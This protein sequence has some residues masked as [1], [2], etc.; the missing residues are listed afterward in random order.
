MATKNYVNNK[1]LLAHI[2]GRR[3]INEQ[4]IKDGLEKLPIDNYLGIVIM[5]IAKR[6]SFRPNFIN[7]SYK[8]EMVSD[9][10]ENGLKVIDNFDPAKSSNPFAYLTQ[11]MWNAFIRRI[12]I[13]QKQQKIKGALI[14]E[15]PL[16]ELFSTQEHDEE[17]VQYSHHIMDF[18]RENNF[19]HDHDDQKES[20]VKIVHKK[21][22]E[23]FF[24]E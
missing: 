20:K 17:G 14:S 15:M 1:E 12:Q 19:S 2:I 11:I 16:D 13:E 23:K 8:S 9:A 21:G 7:Y 5:E 24:D 10:I 22:L 18:L 4:R 3:T 6:L